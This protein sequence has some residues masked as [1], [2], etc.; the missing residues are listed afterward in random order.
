VDGAVAGEVNG[1]N[2]GPPSALRRDLGTGAGYLATRRVGVAFFGAA[3]ENPRVP[4]TKGP[5]V[6]PPPHEA[7]LG[8]KLLEGP[9]MAAVHA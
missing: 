1:A 8:K 5:A 3:M 6:G 9:A 4:A 7:G 2:G